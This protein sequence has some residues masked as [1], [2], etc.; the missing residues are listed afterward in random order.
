MHAVD[1][2]FLAVVLLTATAAVADAV[3]VPGSEYAVGAPAAPESRAAACCCAGGQTA[4]DVPA[5]ETLDATS[6]RVRSI[7]IDGRQCLR[8]LDPRGVRVALPIR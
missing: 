8:H 1:V 4:T 3:V 6:A 2:G 5:P 7:D